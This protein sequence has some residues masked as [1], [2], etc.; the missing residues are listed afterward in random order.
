MFAH[1]VR[2]CEFLK[3]SNMLKVFKNLAVCK[4]L[5]VT[6][7]C[8]FILSL[9]FQ[10]SFSNKLALKSKELKA[11]LLSRTELEKEVSR[12]EFENSKLSS[13]SYVED[14][15]KQKGYVAMSEPLNSI[16]PVSVAVLITQ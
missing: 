16:K 8:L 4:A 11:L 2:R 10:I 1:E 3:E 6:S 13:L 9:S 12:L 5:F 14:R 15:A 7:V